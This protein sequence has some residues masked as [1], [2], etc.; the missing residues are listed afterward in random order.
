MT[1]EEDCEVFPVRVVSHLASILISL[2]TYDVEHL[3][4]YLCAICI[5]S[6]V[7]YLFRTFAHFLTRLLIFILLSFK[8]LYILDNSPLSDVSFADILS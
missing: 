2:L 6:L 1:R 7:M 5:S 3:F 8:S 4:I